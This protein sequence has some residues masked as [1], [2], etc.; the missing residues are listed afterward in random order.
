[1]RTSGASTD[2]QRDLFCFVN[3]CN[4]LVDVG[5]IRNHLPFF[6]GD[7]SSTHWL[8]DLLRRDITGDDQRGYL[9][10]ADRI[11]DGGMQDALALLCG[12]RDFDIAGAFLQYLLRVG[13]LE[14]A[15]A[16]FF[17]RD[18][19]GQCQHAGAVTV[20]VVKPLHQVG[21]S[22]PAGGGAHGE[23]ASNEGFC[24]SGESCGFLIVDVDP[25][26]VFVATHGIN[27]GVQAVTD[28]AVNVSHALFGEGVDKEVC[29][30]F[31]HVVKAPWNA[32]FM[33]NCSTAFQPTPIWQRKN[34]VRLI[35]Q[36]SDYICTD[37]FSVLLAISPTGL[38]GGNDGNR[39]RVF[40]LEG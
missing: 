24:A 37:I 27:D 10:I 32:L 18:V 33:S 29:V 8:I 16:N 22:W 25:F 11:L 39:T 35:L 13:F 36:L 4:E 20:G 6:A 21:I 15:S 9:L 30:G 14:E 2:E 3:G 7:Y 5:S 34:P 17:A 1:M 38:R 23:F 40:S 12:M 31:R 28:E 19:G 26:H